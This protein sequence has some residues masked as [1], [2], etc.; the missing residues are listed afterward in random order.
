VHDLLQNDRRMSIHE[1]VEGVRISCG[2]CQA[3]TTEVYSM[4]ADT[5]AAER[6]LLFLT[7]DLLELQKL[8][9]TS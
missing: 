9:K 5:G 2:S 8:M 3:V 4:A 6:K 1:M 7:S